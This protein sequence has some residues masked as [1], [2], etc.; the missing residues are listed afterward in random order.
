M[1]KQSYLD[2][3][4]LQ[5]EC[6]ECIIILNSELL[7]I[8]KV[9]NNIKLVLSETG[10][11][12]EA[13]EAY[14]KQLRRYFEIFALMKEADKFDIIDY[15]KLKADATKTYDGDLICTSYER[16]KND[17]DRYQSKAN[18]ER[19]KAA[20][21]NTTVT[22][23]LPGGKV[24]VEHIPN[25]YESSAREYQNLADDCQKEMNLWHSKMEEFDAIEARTAGLFVAGKNK[26][27]IAKMKLRTINKTSISGSRTRS[28]G[29]TGGL[30]SYIPDTPKT[31]INEDVLKG[32]KVLEDKLRMMTNEDGTP[33]YTEKEIQEMVEYVIKHY[34]LS[35]SSLYHI[36][37]YYYSNQM[38]LVLQYAMEAKQMIP[39]DRGAD[40]FANY[41][42]NLTNEDGTPMYTEEEIEAMVAY[43][44][45]HH[46]SALSSL[47]YAPSQYYGYAAKQCLDYALEYDF[48]H[49]QSEGFMSDYYMDCFKETTLGDGRTVYWEI[50]HGVDD[51]YTYFYPWDFY[52]PMTNTIDDKGCFY[53]ALCASISVGIQEPYPI[54]RL[55]RDIGGNVQYIKDDSVQYGYRFEVN[56]SPIYTLDGGDMY[57]ALID[58]HNTNVSVSAES[59]SRNNRTRIYDDLKNGDTYMVYTGSHWV[60]LAGLDENGNVV[61]V[62]ANGKTNRTY[63]APIDMVSE[64]NVATMVFDVEVSRK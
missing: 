50:Q 7:E 35:L 15:S 34:P 49:L 12:G 11:K 23:L 17:R 3:K 54:E 63:S 60:T 6:N 18:D 9:S 40:L 55:I 19:S 38:N 31:T 36:P 39:I 22:T 14:K 42:R 8:E 44:L 26:R 1:N 51:T 62:C 58:G 64:L 61:V 2:S 4:Q 46:P 5:T 48:N 25:P 28:G 27:T 30:I 29:G 32:A 45:E 13:M 52:R 53:Y 57:F 56:N 10:L 47:Y 41:L 24:L 20:S 33:K 43:V 16:A 59:V 21:F 37:S